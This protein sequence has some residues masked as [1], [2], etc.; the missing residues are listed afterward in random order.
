VLIMC[1]REGELGDPDE[2]KSAAGGG[3]SFQMG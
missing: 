2:K 1:D 3:E